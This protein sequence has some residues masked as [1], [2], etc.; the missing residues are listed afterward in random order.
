MASKPQ[1]HQHFICEPEISTIKNCLANP[2]DKHNGNE[3][4]RFMI[5]LV[6]NLTKNNQ[7]PE[8]LGALSKK[9]FLDVLVGLLDHE[10]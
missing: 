10:N 9:G 5:K 1:L 6:C 4:V 7:N 2:I 8:I 3:L